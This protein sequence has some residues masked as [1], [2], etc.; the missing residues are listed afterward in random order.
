MVPGECVALTGPAAACSLRLRAIERDAWRI[1]GRLCLGEGWPE[2]GIG[3]TRAAVLRR[4]VVG[5]IGHSRAEWPAK[6]VLDSVTAPALTV[7]RCP[8]VATLVARTVLSA[9]GVSQRLWNAK[10]SALPAITRQ[11]VEIAA[12]LVVD[13]PVLLLDDPLAGLDA[14]GRVAAMRL[15]RRAKRDGSLLIGILDDAAR[16]ELA[17]RIIP[18]DAWN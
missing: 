14:E 6:T 4:S 18:V 13:H 9:L 17:D 10:P 5:W 8:A 15:L 7:G 1:G 3:E 2:T 11:K 12:G 16:A